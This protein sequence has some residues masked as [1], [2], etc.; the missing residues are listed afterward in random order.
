MPQQLAHATDLARIAPATPPLPTAIQATIDRVMRG[1][2]PL[3]LFTTIARDERLAAKFF[4][5]G[6]LDKGN[7]SLRDREI[8]IDRTTALC[9]SEY[10][11]GVH[12]ARFAEAAELNE[13][14]IASLAGDGSVDPCWTT[15]EAALLRLCE[16]LHR[17]CTVDDALWA[18]LAQR[19]T[20]EALLELL[21]LA[22]FYRTVSYLANALRLPLESFAR[23]FP[24]AAVGN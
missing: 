10:E 5:G 16:A 3:A 1:Q 18:E 21:M 12:V 14:Q 23:R 24:V 19:Y 7:I 8:V 6:L 17:D 4:A 11:W 13:A 15:E 22:G 9:G 2:P 20:D